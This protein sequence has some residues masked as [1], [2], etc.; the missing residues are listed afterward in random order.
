V[1]LSDPLAVARDGEDVPELGD[2][3]TQ[4]R[5][6][7]IDELLTRA[8][9]VAR[10]RAALGE[11]DEKERQVMELRFG[12]GDGENCTLQQIGDRLHLSRERIRQIESRAKEKLRRS[13]KAQ[14]LRSTLN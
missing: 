4:D 10:L 9:V 5:V 2:T 6:P 12:L 3:L 1:S 13:K 14:E 11:L 7:P 8:A